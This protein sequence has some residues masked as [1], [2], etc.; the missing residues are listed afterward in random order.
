ME[1]PRS[2]V[3]PADQEIVGLIAATLAYGRVQSI[4]GAIRQVLAALGPTPAR[5]LESGAHLRPEFLREFQYRW[6]RQE[7]LVGLC[8]GMRSIRAESGSMGDA[9]ATYFSNA[10]SLQDGLVRWVGRIR[11]GAAG[12]A[13]PTRGLR[14]LLSDPAGA[15]AS[16]RLHLYLRWMVRPDD[17]ID[18]GTWSRQIAPAELTLPLDTHWVRIAR[19]MGL[20]RRK[21]A[22]RK[23][24]LEITR[25]LRLACPEDPLRY[26]FAVC[27]LGISGDCPPRIGLEHC[28]DCALNG[29]CNSGRRRL[30]RAR[31]R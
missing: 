15:G 31:A 4:R 28:A 25:K 14:F 29:V 20:T 17:G 13:P 6:T 18:L 1:F 26:D 19:R 3:N 9:L 16:K 24:A 23:T 7:D 2:F 12:V 22:D 30:S 10:G 11:E 21:A 5:A 27:H 8:E